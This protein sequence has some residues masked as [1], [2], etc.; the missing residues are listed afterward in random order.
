MK[1]SIP[2][3]NTTCAYCGVGCGIR[4]RVQDPG[5]RQVTL[6]GDPDHPA[7]YGKLC[8]KGATLA[9]TIGLEKRQLAPQI[10][11]REVDWSVATDYVARK[12]TEVLEKHGPDA[13]GLYLSGQLLTE[14]YYVA[15]KFAKG[16]LGTANVDTNSR[17]CMSSSVVGH[18]RAFGE[19]LVPTCYE[20]IDHADLMVLVGSNTAWCHPIVYQRIKNARQNNP[21]LKVV[22]IDPRRTDTCDIADLHLPLRAGTDVLLFNGLLARLFEKGCLDYDFIEAHTDGFREAVRQAIDDTT[23]PAVIADT[24]GLAT[25]DIETFY[26]WFEQTGKTLTFYSQGVNQSITGSD[27]VNAII[28][29]HLATGRIGKPGAGPFSLTGQPNAMGGREVGGLANQ[30]AAHMDFDEDSVDRVARFWK[31]PNMARKPGL[32]TLDLFEAARRGDIKVLWIMATNPAVSLPDN[33]RVREA[34]ENCELVIVSDCIADTDTMAYADVKLPA[35]G[36]GEK[37]GTVTNSERCLSRQRAFL[38]SPGLAKPDWQIVSEVARAMG[39]EAAFSFYEPA[40]VFREHAR[41]SCFENNTGQRQ[42]FFNL[43]PLANIQQAVYDQLKPTQWPLKPALNGRLFSDGRFATASGK[44]RFIS[45]AHRPVANATSEEYPL[46][47]NTGRVRDQWHTMTRTAFAKRLNAHKP[48]PFMEIHPDTATEYGISDGDIVHVESRWGEMLAAAS[49]SEGV[50]REQLFI[51]I[52]WND[53]FSSRGRVGPLVNPDVDDHSGQPELKHTPV[54]IRKETFALYARLWTRREI[55]KPSSDY[56]VKVQ[57]DHAIVYDMAHQQ[58]T[59]WTTLLT[60]SDPASVQYQDPRRNTFRYAWFNGPRLER[61][62]FLSP[63]PLALNEQWI[64][65][66]FSKERL[67]RFERQAL[68]SGMAPGHIEDTGA[69]VCACHSVGEKTILRAISQGC[70][71]AAEIGSATKAGTNCGSCVGELN[72]MIAATLSQP[73]DQGNQLREQQTTGYELPRQ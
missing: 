13:I 57:G 51:P 16:F 18:K 6:E 28:N 30:L 49:V 8:A 72:Q 9:E 7:N 37:D 68:L 65:Q 33:N 26:S 14:D 38:A 73:E 71:S 5:R 15:N 59:E 20:D 50:Q 47:L 48:R 60:G 70:C 44:A 10:R 24:C 63:E 42:R 46:Q 1:S 58:W 27:K 23:D 41:L 67:E 35:Q 61:C 22:V 3:V 34:L 29:C 62:L 2:V 55:R 21:R 53:Q 66:L 64:N 31:A 54:R 4:V 56:W 17:L 25:R 12:I 69:I 39:F 11:G 32:K 36:W 43:E 19:D 40:D 45:T 52:H